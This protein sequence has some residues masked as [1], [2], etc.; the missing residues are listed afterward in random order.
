[1][2]VYKEYK[3]MQEYYIPT[4]GHLRMTGTCMHA[5]SVMSNSFATPWTVAH[6]AP[7]SMEFFR[8]EY[9]SGLPLPPPGDLPTTGIEFTSSVAPELAGGFFTTCATWEAC[10]VILFSQKKEQSNAICSNMDGWTWRLSY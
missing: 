5:C 1:M 9:W 4:L 3:N 6:Q 10:N 2:H 7:L 8:H